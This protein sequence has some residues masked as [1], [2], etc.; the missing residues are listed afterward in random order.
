MSYAYATPV[1]SIANAAG[2][3]GQVADGISNARTWIYR[4]DHGINGELH[5]CGFNGQGQLGTGDTT[6]QTTPFLVSIQ[7]GSKVGKRTN[8][9]NSLSRADVFWRNGNGTNAVWDYFGSNPGNYSAFFPPGVGT[10]WVAKGTGDVT[11]DSK[12]DVVWFQPST[13]LVAIWIMSTP[14]TVASTTFPASVGPGSSWQLQAGGDMDGDAHA[15]LLW[16]DTS[17]GEVLV[18]FMNSAGM[19]DQTLSLGSPSLGYEIKA[20]ADVDGDWL[21]DI[22]WF[23]PSTGQVVIW[24]MHPGGSYTAW[25]PGNVGPAS[26]WDISK[27]GDFDGDG[28]DDFFWRHTSGLTAVWYMNGPTIV[29]AQFLH[30][31]PLADWSAQAIGD[32]DGDGRE[33]ILW[34]S[35]GNQVTR[36]RMQGRAVDKIAEGVNG[37]GAGWQSIQ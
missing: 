13:G 27:V 36:W 18:W 32:Y 7:P 37:V 21:K 28:R 11:G 33:D 34:L 16:R 17:T 30:G 31:V 1:D 5:V 15:D 3:F 24:K 19:I 4:Q 22:V 35:T 20:L 8:L 25:F 23:R 14:G 2:V 12:S 10:N 9:R 29:A 6:A 26:G